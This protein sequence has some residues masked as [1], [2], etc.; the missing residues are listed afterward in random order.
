[1][2][3]NK[4]ILVV[5]ILGDESGAERALQDLERQI[6]HT[7]QVTNQSSKG[8][9]ISW[10]AIG[11]AMLGVV[12]ASA[13]T[14]SATVALN[15]IFAEQGDEM[16]AWAEGMAEYGLSTAQAGAAAAV[17]GAQLKNAGFSAEQMTV[18]TQG[19]IE[20]SA[21]LAQVLGGSAV[22]A[23][24]AMGAALRGEYDS[25]ER[26]GITLTADAVAAEMLR[27]AE[28][29]LTFA[30]EQQ[31]KAVATLSL[32]QQGAT[33]VLKDAEEGTITMQMA[34]DH[35][36]AS[37]FN[38]AGTIGDILSPTLTA[39]FSNVAVVVDELNKQ[40]ASSE[41]LQEI[42][43]LLGDVVAAC[44]EIMDPLLSEALSLV[45][46][47]LDALWSIIGPILTPAIEALAWALDLVADALS[48]VIGWVNS[49]IE[50]FERFIDIVHEA[51]DS[52]TFWNDS[53]Q[54]SAPPTAMM[55]P[56]IG[57]YARAG[58]PVA[59]TQGT[60][61]NVNVNAGMVADE[62]GLAREI[63]RVLRADAARMGRRVA[64]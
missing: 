48:V 41:A 36:K 14:E 9:S 10:A 35:L 16:I 53:Y 49:A 5:Q 46:N 13:M 12:K 7:E 43:A 44:A 33:N 24:Q 27:L 30:S 29:G 60:V 4:S 59:G 40:I 50:A 26:Y 20:T 1:M 55:A 64:A 57:R 31:A 34:T 28:E 25:L 6:Q 23:A 32:I 15:T 63:R 62:H 21:Q 58:M 22:E 8:M 19:L 47:L 38:L 45:T 11:A 56:T 2:A 3:A 54:S 18:I 42:S 51:I 39:M 52:L 37:T 61:I 17:L